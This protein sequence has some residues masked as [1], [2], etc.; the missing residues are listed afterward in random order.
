MD[1]ELA[2]LVWY[3]IIGIISSGAINTMPYELIRIDLIWKALD[4]WDTMVIDIWATQTLG[5]GYIP[6]ALFDLFSSVSDS[7][8]HGWMAIRVAVAV[9]RCGA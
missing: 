5:I 3:V 7:G 8:L 4:M 9:L 2:F 1:G 6:S